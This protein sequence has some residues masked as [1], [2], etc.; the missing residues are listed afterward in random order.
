M[1]FIHHCFDCLCKLRILTE[2]NIVS[3]HLHKPP[4]SH[5][6]VIEG[7]CETAS[8]S[9]AHAQGKVIGVSKKEEN[10]CT[11]DDT[12][13]ANKAEIILEEERG[14]VDEKTTPTAEVRD[15]EPSVD[16][17]L[18]KEQQETGLSVKED[19]VVAVETKEKD[20]SSSNKIS[21]EDEIE[22]SLSIVTEPSIVS[23]TE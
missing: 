18:E 4:N 19:Y 3:L 20:G 21:V 16:L 10:T 6:P 17:P 15:V 8:K 12:T 23:C 2:V 14:E 5:L 9:T 7:D 22:Y 13:V 1:A 11:P